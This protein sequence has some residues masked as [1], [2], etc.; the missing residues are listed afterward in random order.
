MGGLM[1]G[2]QFQGLHIQAKMAAGCVNAGIFWRQSGI[3]WHAGGQ[4]LVRADRAGR[5][6]PYCVRE[7]RWI[8]PPRCAW[9]SGWCQWCGLM[10]CQDGA[11]GSIGFA[12]SAFAQ[13]AGAFWRW[14][15]SL[16]EQFALPS[17]STDTRC[18]LTVAI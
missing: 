4:V 8:L 5:L 12:T 1:S 2:Y 3:R 7:N 13:V 9:I 18:L 11:L 6:T 14:A 16:T 10:A 17:L 15:P